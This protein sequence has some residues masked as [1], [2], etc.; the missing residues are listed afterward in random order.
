MQVEIV[1]CELHPAM[2]STKTKTTAPHFLGPIC[3]WFSIYCCMPAK[4][5]KKS[6]Q[7][8]NFIRRFFSIL[9]PGLITGA[10]DD[11]PSGIPSASLSIPRG[12]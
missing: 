10:A 8:K 1:V 7:K 2:A 5:N 9:G 3:F 6:G 12:G 4:P 11:D